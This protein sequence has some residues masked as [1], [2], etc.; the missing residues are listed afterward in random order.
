MGMVSVTCRIEHHL[1]RT[2]FADVDLIVCLGLGGYPTDKFWI[3]WPILALII[4]AVSQVAAVLGK[5]LGAAGTLLT[6]IVIILL[7]LLLMGRI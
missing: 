3:V 4:Y 1:D 5:L 7:V 6:I 2:R